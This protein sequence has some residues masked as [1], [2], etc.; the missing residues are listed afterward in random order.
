MSAETLYVGLDYHDESVQVSVMDDQGRV[1]A[2][3]FCSTPRYTAAA[4]YSGSMTWPWLS[5]SGRPCMSRN[6][7]VGSMPSAE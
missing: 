3:R 6:T 2:N 1:L 7:V 5:V 4:V